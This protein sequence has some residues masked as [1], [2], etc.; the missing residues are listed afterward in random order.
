MS[1]AVA[2]AVAAICGIAA[3]AQ[4]VTGFG[5]ALVAIPLLSL[6]IGPAPAVV[7]ATLASLVLTTIAAWRERAVVAVAPARRMTLAGVLGM[8]VGLLALTRFDA[9]ALQLLIAA[10]LVALVALSLLGLELPGGRRAQWAAG[11]TSGALLTGTGMNGP[12]L[13]LALHGA[14]LPPRAMRGTLQAVFWWQDLVAVAAFAVVGLIGGDVLLLAAVGCLAI[15]IGWR[16]GNAVFI[17]IPPARFRGVVLVAL[18]V[19]ALVAAV[20]AVA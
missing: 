1:I 4:A 8:P 2:G 18:T 17:R 5:F 9:D 7:L 14:R 13:V 12:P 6:L 10:T 11:A 15:P 16:V 3:T 20:S 19:T